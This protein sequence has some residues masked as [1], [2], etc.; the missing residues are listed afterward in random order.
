M[1]IK[2]EI[3][4]AALA[5]QFKEFAIEAEQEFTKG[6]KQVAAMTHQHV[7][8]MASEELKSSLSTLQ[9]NL[10]F[11]EIQDGLW[12]VAIEQP[13]LWIEEG[14]PANF[15]MKP[16][17]L[18]DGETAKDGHKYRVVPFEH[19]KAPQNMNGYAQNLADRLKSEF[20]QQGVP[21][22]KIEKNAQ[23]SPRVGMLHEFSFGGE[24][25]GKGNTP[26]LDR[27]RVY[28]TQMPSGS[29]RR[30]IFTFRTVS[31]KQTDKW[32]HPGNDPKKF[33]DRA[34]DWA[35]NKWETEVMPEIMERLKK[36]WG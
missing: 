31:D 29:V 33:L 13:A 6:V 1:G 9:K 16:G 21:W 7:A 23:G 26:V 5:A 22:K 2:I 14:L 32:I 12:V 34:V 19:S 25:P 28:Q 11:E 35:M 17:L 3:D 15:D 8:K 18:K 30:D 10:K 27:V 20:K 24:K 4:V 36:T